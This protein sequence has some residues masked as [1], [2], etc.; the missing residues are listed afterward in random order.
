MFEST[1][2]SAAIGADSVSPGVVLP[3]ILSASRRENE[4][5]RI[6]APSGTVFCVN[7]IEV[8]EVM[9]IEAITWVVGKMSTPAMP[10]CE[11]LARM[12]VQRITVTGGKK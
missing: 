10:N 1:H 4:S 6:G 3:S 11:T 12:F 8:F 7:E 9:A 5:P 2:C